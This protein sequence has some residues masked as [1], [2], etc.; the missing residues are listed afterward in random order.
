VRPIPPL[1]ASVGGRARRVEDG[2][3]LVLIGETSGFEYEVLYVLAISTRMR[4]GE[5]LGLQWPDV[6]LDAGKVTIFRSLHR[7]KHRR[8]PEDDISWFELRSE[9]SRQ[10]PHAGFRRS[11]SR[12]CARTSPNS[13]GNAC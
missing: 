5:L 11:P 9:N 7:T 13:S 3:D 8:D 6:D 4:Q 1:S 12:L 2:E 10:P